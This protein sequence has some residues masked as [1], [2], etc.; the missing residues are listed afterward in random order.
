L[1]SFLITGALHLVK[2]DKSVD[3]ELPEDK[4]E[5]EDLKEK[6]KKNK[7]RLRTRGP[8]RKAHVDW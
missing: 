5:D 2:S 4:E 3:N 7:A 1:V 6:E 8:Y